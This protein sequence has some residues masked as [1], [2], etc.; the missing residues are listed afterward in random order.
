MLVSDGPPV[1]VRGAV[2]LVVEVF[3]RTLYKEDDLAVFLQHQR[4]DG[5]S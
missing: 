3:Q 1:L 4:M 5:A 2:S